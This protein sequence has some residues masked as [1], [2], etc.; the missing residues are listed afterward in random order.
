VST[1]P[2]W[3]GTLWRGKKPT[4]SSAIPDIHRKCALWAKAPSAQGTA[5]VRVRHGEARVIR[6][7]FRVC[8]AGQPAF[9]T[10]DES[11]RWSFTGIET[12]QVAFRFPP[13]CFDA[14]SVV[15][16]LH[17]LILFLSAPLKLDSNGSG[18]CSARGR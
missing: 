1:H 17:L 11:A 2:A 7:T 12:S 10:P 18:G 9:W 8:W 13:S 4:K 14:H 15:M 5:A 16:H 3:L 6:R